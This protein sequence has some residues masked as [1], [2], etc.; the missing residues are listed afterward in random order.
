MSLSNPG[1]VKILAET[2]RS[3]GGAGLGEEGEEASDFNFM[4]ANYSSG[5]K[6]FCF[7]NLKCCWFILT[8][9]FR[10][11]MVAIPEFES[12]PVLSKNFVS[13]T[14]QHVVRGSSSLLVLT[15]LESPLQLRRLKLVTRKDN[16]KQPETFFQDVP[17]NMWKSL[18]FILN[19][20]FK[21]SLNKANSFQ[22]I[23]T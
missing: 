14:K 3:E 5:H 6:P 19:S 8:L 21:L 11:G 10:Q 13:G 7:W 2:E 18:R 4:Y 16:L 23:S 17:K 15:C 22:N 20:L 9:Y 12:Y 1:R